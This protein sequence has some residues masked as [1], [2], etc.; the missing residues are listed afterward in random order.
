[1]S[2][3]LARYPVMTVDISASGDFAPVGVMRAPGPAFAAAVRNLKEAAADPAQ[4]NTALYSAASN[5]FGVC[6]LVSS[7][8]TRVLADWLAA[9]IVQEWRIEIPGAGYFAALFAVSR[10]EPAPGAPLTFTLGLRL[11]GRPQL[12]G[13]AKTGA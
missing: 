13:F 10:F 2:I 11:A 8:M 5:V 4:L 6:T 7:G 1:M 12:N 9:Q 3:P